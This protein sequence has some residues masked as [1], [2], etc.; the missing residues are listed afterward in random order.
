MQALTFWKTITGDQSNLLEN[1]ISFLNEQGIRYCVIDGQAVN[2][3][4]ES[5]V[6]L[7]L[8]MVLQSTSSKWCKQCL[9]LIL[10]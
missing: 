8:D 9:H 10:R 1:L 3:Y 4:A 6:S 7:D 5:L 2:A